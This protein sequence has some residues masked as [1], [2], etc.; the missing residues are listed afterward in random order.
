[1][2]KVISHSICLRGFSAWIT[3]ILSGGSLMKTT[4]YSH[5]RVKNNTKEL[6]YE[7]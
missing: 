2:N 4:V 6:K 1:M 7:A 3:T 5:A